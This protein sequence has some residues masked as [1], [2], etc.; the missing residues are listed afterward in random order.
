MLQKSY[1]MHEIYLNVKPLSFKFV[2]YIDSLAQCQ[3]PL[4][5]YR[6]SLLSPNLDCFSQSMPKSCVNWLNPLERVMNI[7]QNTYSDSVQNLNKF[8]RESW[9]KSSV[10]LQNSVVVNET[11]LPVFIINVTVAGNF[12]VISSVKAILKLRFSRVWSPA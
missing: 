3:K 4:K 11:G 6:F 9:R 2:F 10:F 7:F 1:K 8:K 5:M 12:T